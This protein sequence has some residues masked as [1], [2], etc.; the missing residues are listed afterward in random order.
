MN[1]VCHHPK[2]CQRGFTLIELLVVLV[3]ASLGLTLMVPQ[4]A[5]LVPGAEFKAETRKMAAM[6]RHARSVAIVRG[7]AVSFAKQEEDGLLWL[8]SENTP[9]QL[10][11]NINVTVS[12]DH[13]VGNEKKILFFPDGSSTG[14]ALQLSDGSRMGEIRIDWLTGRV[15]SND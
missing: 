8:S 12:V 5:G 6:M 15:S 2:R 14:G 13:Q 1:A 4:F 7:E 9:Y 3:I 10:P 11:D